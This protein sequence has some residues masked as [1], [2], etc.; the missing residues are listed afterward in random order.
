MKCLVDVLNEDLSLSGVKSGLKK[1]DYSLKGHRGFLPGH[2]YD[3]SS[4]MGVH[5]VG[6]YDIIMN[7]IGHFLI[8]SDKDILFIE[9]FNKIPW[10]K[11][12]NVVNRHRIKVL[13][14]KSMNEIIILFKQEEIIK[15]FGLIII[16]PFNYLYQMN[17]ELLKKPIKSVE[18]LN[19]ITKF[20][21]SIKCLF[22]SFISLCNKHQIIIFT[23]GQM[24]VYNQRIN[25][26]TRDEFFNQRILVPIIS[27]KSEISNYYTNRIL[28]FRDWVIEDGDTLNNQS[29]KLLGNGKIEC[30]PNFICIE[31]KSN[32][33]KSIGWFSVDNKFR[34]LDLE[35][36][37]IPENNADQLLNVDY[38]T[39]LINEIVESQS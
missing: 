15:N 22:E 12:K 29:F 9:S 32:N 13:K 26:N 31:P 36:F 5:G 8:T 21:Q 33:K 3:I 28:L 24:D 19:P 23:M 14:V 20:H 35:D 10:F 34:I 27:L 16:E 39:N 1:L 17:L 18:M 7:V 25:T 37:L 38:K 6:Y 4:V 2:L 11:L 30:L